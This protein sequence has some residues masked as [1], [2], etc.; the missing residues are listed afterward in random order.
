MSATRR[1]S[2]QV[3]WASRAPSRRATPIAL[4]D[5]AGAIVAR[6]LAE[7]SSDELVRVKGLKSSEIAHVLPQVAGKAVVHRDQARRAVDG[8]VARVRRAAVR[9][10][11][12]VVLRCVSGALAQTPK[13]SRSCLTY[14]DLAQRAR[15]AASA[16]AITST[17]QRNR[18][19]LVMSHALV[20]KQDE[21]LA[22]NEA[23][24]DAA[25]DKGVQAG[26]LDRL[27]LTPARLKSMSE[28]LKSLSMLPDPIGEVIEGHTLPNGIELTKVRVPLG[29][30][31]DDLR[32]ASRT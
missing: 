26:L 28:A 22:A 32:G 17:E 23:D 8:A 10:S 13:R 1:C 20:T 31:G 11:D 5:A 9:A 30:V 27:E 15:E 14:F 25:R 16:L 18:A 7:M 19:L 2:R 24:M 21:I 6:G 12:A 3:S 29:V 4:L